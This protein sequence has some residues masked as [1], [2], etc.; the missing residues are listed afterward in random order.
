MEGYG[1]DHIHAIEEPTLGK[2]FAEPFATLQGYTPAPRIFEF[3]Y[4]LAPTAPLGEGN[5]CCGTLHG[6]LTPQMF[7]QGVE[8]LGGV[9]GEWS[10]HPTEGA[11]CSLTLNEITPARRTAT[12][13]E[14]V[15][16]VGKKSHRRSVVWL[17]RIDVDDNADV[18]EDPIARELTDGTAD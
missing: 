5:E 4:R 11:E 6:H 18:A 13:Y 16:Y 17:L 8:G 15:E 2:R 9:V 7:E 12:R 14:K 10:I 3:V 1:Y